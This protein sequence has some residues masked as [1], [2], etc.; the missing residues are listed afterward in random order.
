MINYLDVINL[1]LKITFLVFIKLRKRYEGRIKIRLK[2][3][4]TR[5]NRRYRS[6]KLV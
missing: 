6:V 4:N 2:T 3:K 5:S 1:F